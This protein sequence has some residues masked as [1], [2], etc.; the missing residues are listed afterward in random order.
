MHR[1]RLAQPLENAQASWIERRA[2]LLSVW[3]EE[4]RLGVG[5][6][7]PLPG[8]SIDGLE[9]C[10][11]LLLAL[12]WDDFPLIDA[13]DDV[14]GQVRSLIER[15]P[16]SAPA[17]RFALETALLEI[18]AA[19]RGEPLFRLLTPD[20]PPEVFP[21]SL[22]VC[23]LLVDADLPGLIASAEAACAGGIATLKLKIGRRS[24][25]QDLERISLLRSSLPRHVCLRLDANGSPSIGPHELECIARFDPEL[26]EEPGPI[27]RVLELVS[28]PV[29]IALDESLA[30]NDG[31]TLIDRLSSRGLLQAIILKPTMLGGAI[32]CLDLAEHVRDRGID[33]IT[34][35]TLEGRV[36]HAAAAHLAWAL[37]AHG[38]NRRAVG[39]DGH[40]GLEASGAMPYLV[41][42][43]LECAGLGS[44]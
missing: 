35:H 42:P 31:R 26:V 36:A 14:L 19:A 24:F 2:M 21:V 4:G 37:A 6:A 32:A 18:A 44:P 8:Y 3:D 12:N 29:P 41:G 34:T 30:R 23:R 11:R 9:D 5:E 40:P 17:A 16:R 1:T 20:H 43:N 22:P 28:S 13:A 7:A 38:S 15:I 10:A 39:L 33:A 25:D 27:A